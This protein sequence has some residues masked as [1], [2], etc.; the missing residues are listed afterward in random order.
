MSEPLMSLICQRVRRWSF[1]LSA[2]ILLQTCSSFIF[3]YSSRHSLC[4]LSFVRI[5]YTNL[6]RSPF[7]SCLSTVRSQSHICHVLWIKLFISSSNCIIRFQLKA[8][9]SGC[10]QTHFLVFLGLAHVD[11]LDVAAFGVCLRANSKSLAGS[12][13]LGRSPVQLRGCGGLRFLLFLFQH[14]QSRGGQLQVTV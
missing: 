14:R 4:L 1:S 8:D 5:V 10:E 12:F 11:R 2:N 3:M 7:F 13:S 6:R 9:E